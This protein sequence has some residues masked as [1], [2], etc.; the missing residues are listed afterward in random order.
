MVVST[1]GRGVV[2]YWFRVIGFW[3]LLLL[4]ACIR[5]PLLEKS[6]DSCQRCTKAMEA[7]TVKLQ[8]PSVSSFQEVD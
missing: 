4:N 2:C 6:Y 5:Y 7:V 3:P 1:E 8:D